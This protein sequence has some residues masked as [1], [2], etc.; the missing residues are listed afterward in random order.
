M[1]F[2]FVLACVTPPSCWNLYPTLEL[3]EADKENA[4]AK[5]YATYEAMTW[6][7]YQAAQR[8]FYLSDAPAKID[9]P[10]FDEM[11]GMLPPKH[12]T[13]KGNFESFL[14][15]EHHSGVYTHQYVRVE[16][17]FGDDFYFS[18]LVDATDPTTWMTRESLLEACQ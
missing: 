10:K 9:Y 13:S 11:L 6:E 8:A 4:N 16:D 7:A 17:C 14:M 3:A 12:W 15:I 2:D 18:K 5:G 1:L